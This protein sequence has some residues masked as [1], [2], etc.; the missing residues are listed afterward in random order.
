M[1]NIFLLN[2]Y[3]SNGLKIGFVDIIYLVSILLGV[4]TIV[5]RNPIVS[6]L[7]LIGLFINIASL[8]ILV[9]SNYIGLSYILVYVGAVVK[10]INNAAQVKILLYKVLLI[11][12]NCFDSSVI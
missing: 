11:I 1:N 7:F 9:G 2:Y 6:V 3:I 10:C 4:F 5:S 8:L 12:K